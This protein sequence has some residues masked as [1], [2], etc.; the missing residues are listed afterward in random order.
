[1]K[2]T[3]AETWFHEKLYYN[4][5]EKRFEGARKDGTVRHIDCP[6]NLY[7]M[8][9]PAL[10]GLEYPLPQVLVDLCRGLPVIDCGANIGCASVY[11][12]EVLKP[13]ML[14]AFEPDPHSRE[15]YRGNVPKGW[16]M[17]QAITGWNG[18][19]PFHSSDWL[20]TSTIMHEAESTPQ[21]PV[22][23][24]A[25]LSL[26]NVLADIYGDIGVLKL[27][28]E[29]AEYVALQSSVAQLSK[30]R[31]IFLE[32]HNEWL[33]RKCD[34]LL[35]YFVLFHQKSVWMQGVAGYVRL[36]LAKHLSEESLA[37]GEGV[38]LPEEELPEQSPDP[39]EPGPE[40][41][42]SETVECVK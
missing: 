30:V 17:E 28:I 32:Y 14:L 15:Y 12:E 16:L 41:T 20:V 5:D 6:P 27:D 10:S 19:V 39:H 42:E 3:P 33:R 34:A 31:V 18:S 4:F 35:D 2:L 13:R 40:P 36:D 25:C 38:K 23:N 21:K 37:P 1:M 8:L 26:G 9:A 24:T 22:W 11:F 7:E 29:G